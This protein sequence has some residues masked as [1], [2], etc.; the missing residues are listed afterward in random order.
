MSINRTVGRYTLLDFCEAFMIDKVC[1]LSKLTAE[2]K[3]TAHML[4][5]LTIQK[6]RLRFPYL[7][8]VRVK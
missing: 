8:V 2:T 1:F 7:H 5:K 3:L 4:R 6:L